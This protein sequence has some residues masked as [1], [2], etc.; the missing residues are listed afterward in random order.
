MIQACRN[1][2][3]LYL[4]ITP[5]P[6]AAIA[7]KEIPVNS[8]SGGGL[9]PFWQRHCGKLLD[10]VPYVTIAVIGLGL[11]LA[12]FLLIHNLH[13]TAAQKA[14]E[15]PAGRYAT[16]IV[17][18]LE[19]NL[20]MVQSAGSFFSARNDANRWEFFQFAREPL[21]RHPAIEVI[22]WIPRVRAAD[23]DA[24]E[25]EAQEDGLFGFTF[26]Q[27]GLSSAQIVADTRTEYYPIYFVEPFLKNEDRLGQDLASDPAMLA[28]LEQARDSGRMVALQSPSQAEKTGG[29]S[30]LQVIRP[31][32]ETNVVPADR[33]ERQLVL[34]GFLRSTLDL[35]VLVDNAHRQQSGTADLEVAIFNRNAPGDKPIFR[36]PPMSGKILNET[37]T[38]PSAL[39][40][41]STHRFGDQDWSVRITPGQGWQ[42]PA[43]AVGPWSVLVFGL[44]LTALMAQYQVTTRE[45]TRI[46]K[47][48]V[49]ARTAELN[50][51]NKVLAQE[52]G[53][54]KQAEEEMRVAKE[55][56]EIASR[57]K[58]EF[59][60][61]MGH[62]LRTP[63]NAVIGFADILSHETFG[64][65]G[66]PRYRDYVTD[67]GLSGQSLLSIINDI[68]DL[69]TIESEDFCLQEENIDVAEL[70]A[71][72]H[73]NWGAKAHEA[74]L[75]LTG[76]V[77]DGTPALTANRQAVSRIVEILLSNA[78]KF[79]P[80]GG[81]IRVNAGPDDAGHIVLEVSDDGI[82]I[83]PKDQD[84]VFQPFTQ[85]DQTLSRRHEG[86]GLGLTLARR[87]V[88]LHGGSLILESQLGA[89]T[90][91]RALLP[92]GQNHWP[93]GHKETTQRSTRDV[94]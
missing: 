24:Y 21:P 91:V 48:A 56:A 29:D 25:K 31:V 2:W 80:Q 15:G 78:L 77:D 71:M 42:A 35:D 57:A 53:E 49:N 64:P 16:A 84:R 4:P 73:E 30:R 85:V 33:A 87:L 18:A 51:L 54:R 60:A 36:Q 67:I 69:T 66:D 12:A 1:I 94:A 45:R 37:E 22:E 7:S 26:T 43:Q 86:T 70:V 79:T 76:S 9:K 89:G 47:K 38:R 28:K 92:I 59:L 11:S 63:L 50:H 3:R 74:G 23:R 65:L 32:Y 52:I 55:K 61:M 72:V 81:H 88:E 8:G 14:F 93:K 44:L 27:T 6:G 90:R 58:S 40:F 39:Q 10:A 75:A 34:L 46:I 82:G 5:G 13:K 20:E 68:L 19:S 17:K 62:E 83:A 41:V